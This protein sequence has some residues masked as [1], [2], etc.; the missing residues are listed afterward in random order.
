[1]FLDARGVP[2][3]SELRYDLCIIG[4]GAAGITLA[5]ELTRAG[6]SV[7]V[8]ESGGFTSDERVQL[9]Y[10]GDNV[11]HDYTPL[12]QTRVRMFGGSTGHWEGWCRPLDPVDFIERP[13]V[14]GSGWPLARSELDPYYA[15]AQKV[16]QLGPYEYDPDYWVRRIGAAPLARSDPRVAAAVFQFSP[17]TRFGAV[18][19]AQLRRARNVRI[20]LH[21]NA[22]GFD[23]PGGRR[24]ERVRV[25]TL[26]GQRFS[27][28]SPL[29]VLATGGI[30]NAR[31]L[32]A[33]GLGNQHDLVGRYFADHLHAP[34]ALVALP[35]SP[36]VT[37]FYALHKGLAGAT[38]RGVSTLSKQAERAHQSLRF[39]AVLAPVEEDPF[40]RRSEESERR[41]EKRGAAVGSVARALDGGPERR[42]FSLF[43]RAEQAPNAD[44]RV[45]LD[46][47]RDALGVRKA[48][49]DWQLGDL[50]RQSVVVSVRTFAAAL[51]AAGIGRVYSR[52]LVED[53]F[54]PRIFGGNHHIGTTRMHRNPRQGVVDGD[55]LV[56]GVDNLYV[57]GS[58][59]FPTSGYANP[60]LTIVALALRLADHL[61]RRLR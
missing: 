12:T 54:W 47:Q 48:R 4:A 37:S 2:Q 21:A 6:T 3:G 25:A 29:V 20:F 57:A 44:S 24:I 7:C 55:C 36:A 27:V 16:C 28:A 53:D 15:R 50:D 59:V 56:H 17:P 18:Y 8:L 38:I 19:R 26:S 43:M 49:L 30:E 9:L 23:S 11:G 41:A 61:R 60:T 33:S 34:V 10:D 35:G 1:M 13:W 51:G 14:S 32:L 52:P 31:L 5:R 22:V 45:T 46:D 42:L 40:V 39:S 58:S